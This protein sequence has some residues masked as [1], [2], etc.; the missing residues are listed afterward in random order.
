[1]SNVDKFLNKMIAL[2]SKEYLTDL[3]ITQN[4]SKYE[5]CNILDV[6]LSS[7]NKILAYYNITKDKNR[8][9]GEKLKQTNQ[10]KFNTLLN[11]IT[12]DSILKY[13]IEENHTYNECL[14]YFKVTG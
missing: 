9:Q 5:L 11:E 13:Y 12:K 7:L 14:E 1:M 4:K 2:Y 3:Y 6:C 10:E 8:A